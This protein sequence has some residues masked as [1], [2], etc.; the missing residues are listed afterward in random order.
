MARA[1]WYWHQHISP[2]PLQARKSS[3]LFWADQRLPIT[4]LEL[5]SGAK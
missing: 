4:V 3:A 2:A 1:F 5:H